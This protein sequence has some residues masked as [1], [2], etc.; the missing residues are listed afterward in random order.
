[1]L[2][3]LGYENPAADPVSYIS[4]VTDEAGVGIALID[5]HEGHFVIDLN[6][7]D[8]GGDPNHVNI[9]VSWLQGEGVFPA[10][11][12]S[13]GVESATLHWEEPEEMVDLLV[14]IKNGEDFGEWKS[15]AFDDSWGL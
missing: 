11:H 14:W 4:Q 12:V 9:R 7:L 15:D 10:F 3:L 2:K 13:N 8:N 6:G 5:F 1:M